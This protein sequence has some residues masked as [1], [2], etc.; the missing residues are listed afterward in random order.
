LTIIVIGLFATS[1]ERLTSG[2]AAKDESPPCDAVIVHVPADTIVTES[3]DTVH[4][5]TVDDPNATGSCDGCDDDA[6]TANA[7][8]AKAKSPYVLAVNGSKV[9]VWLIN[10]AVTVCV[11]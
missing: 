11:T 6:D 10:P 1:N 4:T 2:A 8:T 5:L 3:F 9:M 7:A